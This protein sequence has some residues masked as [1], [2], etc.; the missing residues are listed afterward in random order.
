VRL[1]VTGL[2]G[3]IGKALLPL[4]NSKDVYAIGRSRPPDSF[5]GSFFLIDLNEHDKVKL[6]VDEIRP[7]A[8]I[9]LA[10]QDIP[11]FDDV[12]CL[13]NFANSLNLISRLV[14]V[15][16]RKVIQ[17]GTCMEYLGL[18]GGCSENQLGSKLNLFGRFKHSL[19]LISE[20][21]LKEIDYHWIRPFYIY[22]PGQRE[23][24][25]LPH[26][27]REFKIGNTP[28]LNFPNECNDYIHVNDVAR[29]ISHVLNNK[30][31]AKI[32]NAGSGRLIRNS[33]IC[34]Y[35]Q[36][37][38]NQCLKTDEY[39]LP[40]VV[41]STGFYADMS[42]ANNLGFVNKTSFASGVKLMYESIGE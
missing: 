33:D 5:L 12:T 34:R 15:D 20:E 3:F 14:D 22:G 9:H 40:R 13:A 21:I 7:D 6:L 16:C 8:C 19:N 17:V 28:S 41:H 2:S 25:L 30:T 37:L 42:L 27:L 39:I 23:A 10:W 31:E 11:I 24:A 1:L 35:V 32:I 29:L 38:D 18:S 26:I 36:A 4:I